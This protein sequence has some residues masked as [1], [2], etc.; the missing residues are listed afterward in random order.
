MEDGNGVVNAVNPQCVDESEVNV[1]LSDDDVHL[2]DG[3]VV[4]KSE[5]LRMMSLMSMRMLTTMLT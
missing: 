4:V 1:K 5:L 2:N 3:K